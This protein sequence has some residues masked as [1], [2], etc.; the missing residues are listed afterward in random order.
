[1]S[2]STI[3][4]VMSLDSHSGVPSV[5]NPTPATEPI[6]SPFGSDPVDPPPEMDYSAVA[7]ILAPIQESLNEAAMEAGYPSPPINTPEVG[8]PA[9][10]V[11]Y[12]QPI[13]RGRGFSVIGDR[14][15]QLKIDD[16]KQRHRD[17]DMSSSNYSPEP[18]VAGDEEADIASISEVLSENGR[19]K[20][21]SADARKVPAS[22]GITTGSVP[23]ALG[24]PA[25]NPR[26]AEYLSFTSN[27]LPTNSVAPCFPSTLMETSTESIKTVVDGSDHASLKSDGVTE[28]SNWAE[29]LEDAV[30]RACMRLEQLAE[31]EVKSDSSKS[32]EDYY[33]ARLERLLGSAK[34]S[35]PVH[36]QKVKAV[37]EETA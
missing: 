7:R 1:M 12:R 28:K 35:V 4:K 30:D 29:E 36:I 25:V 33:I 21:G 5:P 20:Q 2:T 22:L 11:I 6:T 16:R 32:F 34:R 19:D 26:I 24:S 18:S 15:A 10:S 27:D 37:R 9:P 14:L 31:D 13:T 8:S 23:I 17:A 3:T